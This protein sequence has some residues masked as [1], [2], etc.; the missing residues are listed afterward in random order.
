MA[1][2]KLWLDTRSSNKKKQSPIKVLI[3]ANNTT[4][5]ISTG[6]YVDKNYWDADS[7]KVFSIS[8]RF[9]LNA[10][11]ASIKCKVFKYPVV[12]ILICCGK[13]RF[14]YW[15]TSHAKLVTLGLVSLHATTTSRRLSRLQ[16]CPNM[17]A[18]S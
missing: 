2:T 13:C 12:T 17:S 1:N 4:A 5:L 14:R 15:I 6:A 3:C 18:M 11:A 16:S 9:T 10:K 8:D 7:E